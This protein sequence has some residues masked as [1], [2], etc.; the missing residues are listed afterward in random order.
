MPAAV[1]TLYQK[2][3]KQ[4]QSPQ[5]QDLVQA[6][7]SSC[8][9]HNVVYIIIDALDECESKSRNRLLNLLDELK[10]CAKVFV[11]SRP[12]PDEIR[13][14]FRCTPQI[15][16]KAHSADLERYINGQIEG[17]EIIDDIGD[18]FRKQLVSK[19]VQNAQ[20]M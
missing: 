7:S 1:A 13:K 3:G 8:R 17:S 6:L 11:T 10:K 2:F 18:A 4:Q 20:E 16:I 19:I 12:Y 9:E 14:A 5:L 15:E